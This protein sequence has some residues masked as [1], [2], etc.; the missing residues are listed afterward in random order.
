MHMP[1][2]CHALAKVSTTH[3]Y[4]E[5]VT[6]HKRLSEL[7]IR[8]RVPQ[9]DRHRLHAACPPHAHRMPTACPP[10]AHRPVPQ[11]LLRMPSM[12]S[13]RLFNTLD[14]QYLG[15]KQRLLQAYLQYGP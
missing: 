10:H 8:L 5:F 9:V 13:T 3:R 12:P 11:L 15:T 7:V 4:S 1:R 14:R 6:L 2:T